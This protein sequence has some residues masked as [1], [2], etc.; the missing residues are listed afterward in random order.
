MTIFCT[1]PEVA[2][3]HSLQVVFIFVNQ[4]YYQTTKPM[5][6]GCHSPAEVELPG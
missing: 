6:M 1:I 5:A 2:C 3:L 4:G